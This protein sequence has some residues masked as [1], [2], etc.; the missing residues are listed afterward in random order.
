MRSRLAWLI[1]VPLMAAG[2]LAA[3]SLSYLVAP[4]V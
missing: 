4:A 2:S 3:H 1:A